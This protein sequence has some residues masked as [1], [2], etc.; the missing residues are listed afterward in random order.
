MLGVDILGLPDAFVPLVGGPLPAAGAVT[1]A[2]A[3][4]A[5]HVAALP[6]SSGTT[7]KPK[8]V[9]LTHRNL[10]ANIAQLNDVA[11]PNHPIVPEDV[12]LGLLPM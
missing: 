3:V 2:C 6:Y 10:I 8:G 7:G 1:A 11:E 12:S 5:E 9:M 4:D